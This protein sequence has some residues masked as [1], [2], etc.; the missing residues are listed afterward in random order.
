MRVWYYLPIPQ[1]FKLVLG[2]VFGG[3][4]T[5]F[6][7]EHVV[8]FH[9][10]HAE[11][12][13]P[14]ALA[15]TV[16]VGVTYAALEAALGFSALLRVPFLGAG[17]GV[18]TSLLSP[19]LWPTVLPLCFSS[20]FYEMLF[21]DSGDVEMLRRVY[22]EIFVPVIFPVSI[23]AGSA[24]EMVLLPLSQGV[25]SSPQ[26]WV[27]AAAL[28]AAGAAYHYTCR[29]NSDEY[30]WESRTGVD[31]SE[32]SVNLKTREVLLDGGTHAREAG[33]KRTAFEV[34][35]YFRAG[36][37]WLHR[38]AVVNPDESNSSLILAGDVGGSW[39]NQAQSSHS[40]AGNNTTTSLT[41]KV[42]NQRAQMLPLLDGL[43]RFKHL[44][45]QPS[46]SS[47]SSSPRRDEQLAALGAHLKLEY[48]L[49]DVNGFILD[50]EEMMIAGDKAGCK[51]RLDAFTAAHADN[52]ALLLLNN[53]ALFRSELETKTGYVVGDQ[54]SMSAIEERRRS[55]FYTRV[56]WGV[57]LTAALSAAVGLA[58]L[59]TSRT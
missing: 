9:L 55:I 49:G 2:V 31:G 6:V 43:V 14:F 29:D 53:L 30:W 35:N 47:S 1:A 58:T 38:A 23:L 34:L 27:V 44:Q 40:T 20:D 21:P 46:S 39:A 33:V 32:M 24:L 28:G 13:L 17:L 10:N 37:S 5:Y 25:V 26:G 7:V 19:I 42:A 12:I 18:S 59:A 54:A 4:V 51:E 15:N 3:G 11:I 56:A 57:A 8:P 41:L 52:S 36:L 50:C 48:G 16:S 45:L 22:Y